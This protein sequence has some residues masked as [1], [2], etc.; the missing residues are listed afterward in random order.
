MN[1]QGVMQTGLKKI[2]GMKYYFDSQG[3]KTLGWITVGGKKYFFSPS[4]GGRAATGYWDINN[5]FYYF[6]SE[7]VLNG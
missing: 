7:G 2:D 5:V 3:R 6:N 4:A 1:K